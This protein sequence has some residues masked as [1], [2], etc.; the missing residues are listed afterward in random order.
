MARQPANPTKYT[1]QY[2]DNLSFDDAFRLHARLGLKFDGT[3]AV[4]DI[5]GEMACKIV[6]ADTITYIAK[7]PP[8]TAEASALWQAKKLDSSVAGT[9]VTTWADGN[10]NFD[11]VATDLSALTYS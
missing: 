11:N 9:T 8:G 4:Y 2:M 3:N 1:S 6:T 5:A 7:A 10:T